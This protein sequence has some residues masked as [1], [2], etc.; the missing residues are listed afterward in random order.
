MRSTDAMAVIFIMHNYFSKYP[1]D[2]PNISLSPGPTFYFEKGKNITLPKCHVTSFPPAVITWS[3]VRGELAYSRTVVEDGQLSI[4]SAQKRDSGLYECK[5]SNDLGDDS[6]LTLLS[7][8][9]LPRFTSNPP[10]QLNVRQEQNISVSCQAAGDPKPKIMWVRENSQ[11][12][13]GRS[14]VSPE[15]TLQIWN[16][17]DEDSGIYIC[18]AISA[19][20]FKRSLMQLTVGKEWFA[21]VTFHWAVIYFS[22]H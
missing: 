18:I 6:A 4:I 16:I 17:K 8:L 22:P 5:A 9:E 10:A 21:S 1:T 12:P 3:R 20:L 11:L 2:K 14:Q 7:V 13:V 15:G 19:Q